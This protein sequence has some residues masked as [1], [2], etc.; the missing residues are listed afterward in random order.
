MA[1]TRNPDPRADKLA[2]LAERY[3][4]SIRESIDDC[5]DSAEEDLFMHL[6]HGDDGADPEPIHRWAAVTS[7]GE[8][9]FIYPLFDD[10]EGAE[11][12]ATEYPDDD[13]YAESPVAV[14]DLDG[15][16]P[17]GTVYRLVRLIAVFE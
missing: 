2:A 8:F 4:I 1:L 3:G 17:Y 15:P 7:A 14:V 5:K 9:H 10:R 16:E 11:E 6:F 13:I 12:R